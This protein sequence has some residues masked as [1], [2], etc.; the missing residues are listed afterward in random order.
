MGPA[1]S[2]DQSSLT[3]DVPRRVKLVD[4]LMQSC[5]VIPDYTYIN[6]FS[7][8]FFIWPSF[9]PRMSLPCRIENPRYLESEPAVYGENKIVDEASNVEVISYS[10][11]YV[12]T[13]GQIFTPSSLPVSQS[14]RN[15][16]L[17]T[18][19]TSHV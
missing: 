9:S 15:Q 14:P 12:K 4:E 17:G 13:H 18:S 11:I 19:Q 1:N 7:L 10:N 3:V 8:P 16:V 6:T 2:G 5:S